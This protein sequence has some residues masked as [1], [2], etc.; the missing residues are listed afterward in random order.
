[1]PKGA[2]SIFVEPLYMDCEW[3]L[4]VDFEA[5]GFLSVVYS[6]SKASKG[7]C[8]CWPWRLYTQT[9]QVRTYLNI[10]N[11]SCKWRQSR[12][13]NLNLFDSVFCQM[14]WLKLNCLTS[15]LMIPTCSNKFKSTFWRTTGYLYK[16]QAAKFGLWAKLPF[17]LYISIVQLTWKLLRVL[18]VA[19]LLGLIH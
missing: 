3:R 18:V 6:L 19:Y 10:W 5:V 9:L 17:T 11:P 7:V 8:L 14:D 13:H 2:L 4:R 12:I 15:H 1:M 16:V